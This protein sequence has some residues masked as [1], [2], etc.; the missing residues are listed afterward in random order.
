MTQYEILKQYFGY[1]TFR[2]GQD[3]LINSIL[4]GRDVLGVMPT[5]AGKS[6]CYQY[7]LLHR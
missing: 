1:D 7:R 3:V 5:G 4:E 6:L 2:D